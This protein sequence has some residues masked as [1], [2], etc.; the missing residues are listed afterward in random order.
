MTK[1]LKQR[2]Y[3]LK[4]LFFVRK[5]FH[6]Y[7]IWFPQ[8]SPR[9]CKG[10]S[11][12]NCRLFFILS[13][14]LISLLGIWILLSPF[15]CKAVHQTTSFQRYKRSFLQN[16]IVIFW[17]SMRWIISFSLVGIGTRCCSIEYI[18]MS[19]T[20]VDIAIL[21]RGSLLHIWWECPLIHDFWAQILRLYTTVTGAIAPNTLKTTLLSI[22]PGSFK[23]I[24]KGLLR[25]WLTAVRSVIPHH[26]RSAQVHSVT[27]WV[28]EMDYI[29]RIGSL[30]A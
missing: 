4:L 18:Q 16:T 6:P 19:L 7:R 29:E 5:L 26:W 24:K 14:H 3:N 8:N 25:H 17:N 27:E 23:C 20:Y 11:I 12:G 21:L 15:F 1:K 28:T 30:L 13:F 2:R 22:L 10:W 9:L